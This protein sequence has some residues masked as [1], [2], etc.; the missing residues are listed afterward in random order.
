MFF[1][2]TYHQVFKTVWQLVDHGNFKIQ[3]VK[4]TQVAYV[5]RHFCDQCVAKVEELQLLEGGDEGREGS[6]GVPAD[7]QL[8]EGGG[9][10]R[11]VCRH[12]FET[13]ACHK[14]A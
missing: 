2:I 14:Q 10:V 4:V 11:Q 8:G 9:K 7:V 3:G 5:C 6:D 12:L 1:N 13:V